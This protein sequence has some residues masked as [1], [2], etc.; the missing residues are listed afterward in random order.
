MECQYEENDMINDEFTKQN[1]YIE[2]LENCLE[3]L[4]DKNKE[5]EYKF[6][7]LEAQV[8]ILKNEIMSYNIK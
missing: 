1:K 5:N 2:L 8:E 6:K 7:V 3:K 4:Y